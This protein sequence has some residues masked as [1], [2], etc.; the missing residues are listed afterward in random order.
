MR[1][2]IAQRAQMSGGGEF[3]YMGYCPETLSSYSSM[4]RRK[5]ETGSRFGDCVQEKMSN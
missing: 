5:G 3:V 2:T 1:C 4:D